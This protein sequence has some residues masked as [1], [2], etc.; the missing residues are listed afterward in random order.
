MDDT[1]LHQAVIA[2]A[3]DMGLVHVALQVH[4]TLGGADP[5]Q[6]TSLDHAIWFH[7]AA[8]ANDWLLHVQRSPVTAEGRGLSH[9]VI[10]ARDGRLVGSVAQE[11][12]ARRATWPADL[13]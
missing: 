8:D 3:S 1:A 13:A 11:F 7:K 12:L 4:G 9:G 2:F 10:Y 5:L 6:A